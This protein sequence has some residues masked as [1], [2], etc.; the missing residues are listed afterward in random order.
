MGEGIHDCGVGLGF[1]YIW[2][3]K[4]RQYPTILKD[5]LEPVGAIFSEIMKSC[6]IYA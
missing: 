2:M 6:R 4:K 3:W 5:I 1:Y